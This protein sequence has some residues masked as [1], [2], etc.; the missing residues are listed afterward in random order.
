LWSSPETF[1][2]LNACPVD[3]ASIW[4]IDTKNFMTSEQA[5]VKLSH[6]HISG[7]WTTVITK[8]QWDWYA[9]YLQ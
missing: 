1:D 3:M 6:S 2:A 5:Q 9:E 7:V 8:K 4:A